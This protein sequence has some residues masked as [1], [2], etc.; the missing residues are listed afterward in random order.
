MV[1]SGATVRSTSG[2]KQWL[3]NLSM[4][5]APGVLLQQYSCVSL[6][7]LELGIQEPLIL[8][9]SLGSLYSLTY[10][11]PGDVFCVL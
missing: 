10:T 5:R 8:K 3:S 1:S 6:R 7:K 2:F 11:T 4:H 9:T